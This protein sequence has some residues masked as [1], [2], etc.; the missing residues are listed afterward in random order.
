VLAL[1]LGFTPVMYPAPAGP[2]HRAAHGT[3]PPRPAPPPGHRGAAP[4]Q[5][6]VLPDA[7][8][9]EPHGLSAAQVTRIGKLP[10]VRSVLAL[11]GARITADGRPVNVVGV[12]PRLFRSW[13]P[14][15]TA[16]SARLW[17]ALGAGGFVTSRQLR[18]RLRLQP[19]ASY[20]LTGAATRNLAFGG[21]GQLGVAGIDVVVSNRA[22]AGLGLIHDVAA[23]ISAPGA[24]MAALLREAR[25]VAGAGGTVTGVRPRQLVVDQ[26]AAGARPASYLDLFRESAA[27]YCPGLSWTVLAAIGQIESGDG[28]DP[29]PSTAGALGPMQFL[30][31]TWARWGITAFGEP[32]PPNVMDPYDAVPSAARYLCVSGGAAPGG[33]YGAIYAYNHADWYV[34]DVLALAQQYARQYG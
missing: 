22:S 27:G 30:P 1:I 7:V 6:I 15:R 10:G 29:G 19:G 25:G 18:S 12:D 3:R 17:S 34:R 28:A 32:G 13:T 2:A 4:F 11:D 14:L 21:S 33:L 8:V 26:A 9:I 24:G 31:S 16:S 23:L 20:R 5:R